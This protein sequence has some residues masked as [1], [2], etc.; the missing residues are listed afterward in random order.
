LSQSNIFSKN[1]ISAFGN[2]L[3]NDVKFQDFDFACQS[4]LT[5]SNAQ[6]YRGTIQ[7][8]RSNVAKVLDDK[9]QVN[10]LYLGGCTRI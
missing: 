5:S 10:D 4:S 7:S 1:W 3:D 2:P 6:A 9:G 8:I